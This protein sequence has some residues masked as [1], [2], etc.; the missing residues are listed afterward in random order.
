MIK[1]ITILLISLILAAW[2]A[3]TAILSV[4]NA[5]PVSLTFLNFHSIQ[6]PV[7]LVLAFSTC[8]GIIFV[9]LLQPLW[10]LAGAGQDS[11]R[12]DDED[13]FFTDD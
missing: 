6:L 10:S 11:L 13:D 2:I 9:A 1:I 3:A 5:T 7:G 8:V 4:Q 12:A